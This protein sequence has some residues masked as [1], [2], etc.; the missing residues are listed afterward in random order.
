MVGYISF[1]SSLTSCPV[2]LQRSDMTEEEPSLRHRSHG[3]VGER[4]D[5]GTHNIS[6]F[7]TNANM[8]M[9]RM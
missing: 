7:G 9:K 8:K 2:E 5:E 4:E 1:S 6:L 3:S